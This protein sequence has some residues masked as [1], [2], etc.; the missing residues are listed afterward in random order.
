MKRIVFLVIGLD[1]LGHSETVEYVTFFYN[2]EVSFS[3]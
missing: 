3:T 2:S 1:N